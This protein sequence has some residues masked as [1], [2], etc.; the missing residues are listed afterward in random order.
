MKS[1]NI[2]LHISFHNPETV[3][4]MLPELAVRGVSGMRFAAILTEC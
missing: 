1:E 4:M 2:C 3:K